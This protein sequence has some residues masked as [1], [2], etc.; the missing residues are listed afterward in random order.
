[1]SG[2]Y[3]FYVHAFGVGIPL[4]AIAIASMGAFRAS[5]TPNQL[6]VFITVAAVIFGGWFAV[7]LPFTRSG[8][9]NVPAE[10]G[11]PPYVL[12]FLFGGAVLIWALAWLTPLGRRMTDA[13]PLGAIAAF[14]IPRIM[15]GLFLIGW[16]VGDIPA[17][18]ALP[19]GLGDILAGIAGWQASRALA[20]GAPNAR[21]L[22]ARATFIG[23]V[24][25]FF[26]VLFGIITSPG[27]A[28]L[29]ALDAPNIINDYPLA[30]FPGFFVPIF[31]GF[32][33]IAISRLR[34]ESRTSSEALA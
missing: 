24:D 19:A 31:L 20:N 17:L 28:H 33:F 3:E 29:Y 16:A 34:Q 1:M 18:F 4:L 5:F 8:I 23:I 14:Q 6:A 7:A 22:L 2:F 10:L 15:G 11:D 27:F 32:H 9:F 26:A 12:M 30:M 13:I 25:F 21:Y